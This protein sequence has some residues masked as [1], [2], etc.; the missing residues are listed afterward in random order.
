MFVEILWEELAMINVPRFKAHLQTEELPDEGVFV[1][2]EKG[3]TLLRGRLYGVIAPLIDGRRSADDIVDQLDRRL[4]PAEVYHALSQLERNGYLAEANGCGANGTEAFWTMQEIN[5]G[6]A[7]QRLA[8]TT[9]VVISLAG[10]E[11]SPLLTALGELHVRAGDR[12]QLGVVL[13]DDYLRAGL[14]GYNREA[15]SSGRSW[16]LVKPVGCQI[17]IGPVFVPHKTGCWECLVQRLRRNREAESFL[18]TKKGRV[19]PFPLPRADTPTTRAVAWNLAATEIAR[20]IARGASPDLEGRILTVNVLDWKTQTHVLPRQPHCPACGD[21]EQRRGREALSHREDSAIVLQSRVKM[22]T[23]D[24]GHRAFSPEET[25]RRYEHHVSPVTGAVTALERWPSLGDGVLNVY[26]SGHNF[27]RGPRSLAGLRSG[28]RSRC[29]GKGSSDVQAKASAL[30][31]ALERYSGVFQGDEPRTASRR[32]RDLGEAA[33]HPNACMQYS[34]LQYR[35]RAALNARQSPWNWVPE[36]FNED[37]PVE[38]TP[39]WSLTRQAVRYLPTAFCYYDYPQEPESC[40]ACS[41]GNAAGNT[42]EEAILQGFFELV[43]RD[44][45]ALW[46]YNRVRR[47]ALDLDR[48]DEPYLAQVAACLRSQ[49]R[50]LWA[51]DL[52]TDLGIPVFAALSRRTDRQPEEILM[53]F[54]AHFD[55]RLALLRAVT[56][57]NQMLSWVLTDAAGK[58]LTPHALSDAETLEWLRTATL[59]NQQYLAP[60]A[61]M[62]PR[63]LADYPECHT[64]DIRDDV[65]ACQALVE[66]KGLEMLVLDQ[67]R[68][69]I[70]LPV[71]KVIVPGLRHFWA[72]HAPGRLYHVPVQLGW[73][74]QPLREEQL[75]PIPLFL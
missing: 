1:L 71:V 47:P 70:G 34:E 43:E 61:G 52:T 11:V 27:A 24:G 31:E 15:L 29:A 8:V 51:L 26:G 32:L 50:E 19:E 35:Q 44:S 38:W 40:F 4:T 73:L 33:I 5:P 23:R 16:L 22:F 36:P 13:T 74:R 75:N 41:N 17:W 66:A 64:D 28:L 18:Q 69:D 42:L 2:S 30:C 57:L 63:V 6:D 20:W 62:Q 54:G 3:A 25:L 60:D 12:G 46:W 14:D 48:F 55:A 72:R 59:A 58:P 65:L 67:T 37:A 56:E 45:V 7:A 68:A 53:G 39:V 10:L 9:V 49:H 21:S